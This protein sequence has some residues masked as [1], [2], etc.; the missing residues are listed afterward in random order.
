MTQRMTQDHACERCL[1]RTWLLGELAGNLENVRA[2]VADVLA[3]D[4]PQLIQSIGGRRRDEIRREYRT[5]PGN[6][7]SGLRERAAAAGADLVCACSA[8]YPEALRDLPGPPAVLHVLGGL[9]RLRDA[10][11]Q[12]PVAIV[13]ARRCTP[14]GREVARTM[15]RG[16]AAAGLTVV[17]GMALGIDGAAHTG[18]LAAGAPGAATI[19]VMPG[20]VDVAYPATNR[21]LYGEVVERGVAV[22]EC[23]A[24]L[25]PRRWCFVARN[26]IIA[27]LSRGTVV[28]EAG[29]RSGALLT[30]LIA[31]KL[32]RHVAVVPGKV[33]SDQSQGTNGLLVEGFPLW[34]PP[35]AVVAVR[36]AQDVLNLVCG[37]GERSAPADQRPP[38][39]PAHRDLL[40]AVAAGADTSA[41]LAARRGSRGVGADLAALAELEL[42]GWVRR[43]TGG[44]FTVI[45]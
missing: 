41:A 22:S 31:A 10:C 28:V 24:G 26:R 33:T 43:G 9:E 14:Y 23:Y 25:K 42:A 30:A 4:D 38:L 6:V 34:M 8:L 21:R 1:T 39:S 19:A 12:D 35:R 17:S 27:A 15:A 37:I 29:A 3:L 45:P 16:L 7:T 18:A 5:V 44:R 40:A 2:D 13:G 11:R 36:G 32:Q 20:G